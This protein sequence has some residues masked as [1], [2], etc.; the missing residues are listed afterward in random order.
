V[1]GYEQPR[2]PRRPVGG[3]SEVASHLAGGDFATWL[4]KY[5]RPH[6]EMAH[7]TGDL[8]DAKCVLLA[9]SSR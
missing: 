8:A 3:I 9:G 6:G 2:S 1:P 4:A 5:S 7:Q